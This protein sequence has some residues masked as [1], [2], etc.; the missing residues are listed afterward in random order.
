MTLAVK[1]I[2]F[3]SLNLIFL[4][5]LIF[6][7]TKSGDTLSRS[8]Q[9]SLSLILLNNPPQTPLYQEF[10]FDWPFLL[11]RAWWLMLF[12]SVYAW[13]TLPDRLFGYILAFLIFIHLCWYLG[14]KNAPS[15]EDDRIIMLNGNWGIIFKSVAA[16]SWLEAKSLAELDLRKRNLLVLAIKRD[17][18]VISFPKGVEILQTG[19]RTV[20]FGDLNWINGP[21]KQP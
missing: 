19:D 2:I 16:G 5:Y 13:L 4:S 21:G 3:I 14:G 1:L 7:L 12:L 11:R 9:L 18:K 17:H 6:I 8:F 15:E 20:I 10:K